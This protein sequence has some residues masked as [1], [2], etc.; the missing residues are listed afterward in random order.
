MMRVLVTGAGG[1]IGRHLVTSQ[2]TQG[3]QVRAADSSR[4]RLE[5]LEENPKLEVLTADITVNSDV[6]ALLDGIDQVFHLASAHLEVSKAKSDYWR[7]NVSAVRDLL[8]AAHLAGVQRFLHC[9]SVGVYGDIADLPADENSPCHPTNTYEI[10]KLEGERE[11]LNLAKELS[12]SVIVVR[13]AWVYGPGCP[14][15]ERLLRAIREGRFFF[16]GKGNNLRHPVY[17]ADAVRGLELGLERG[18]PGEIYIIAGEKPVS[19]K[20]LA[21]T[22]AEIQGVPQ[23]RLHLPLWLGFLAGHS[24]ERS[25]SL[26]RRQP[27]FSRRT[28]DVFVRDS[29]YSIDKARNE[30][31]FRPEMD[32]MNGLNLTLQAS[33]LKWSASGNL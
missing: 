16:F 6:R 25:F 21:N 3:Q 15:T 28:M 13:P 26:F 11:A 31:G 2:L 22:V 10:T 8:Y 4:E 20:I 9:S 32:L 12:M 27:P 14:R 17:V 1:F 23:P 24:L 33:D 19:L 5:K 30:L 29:S 7:V 18:R